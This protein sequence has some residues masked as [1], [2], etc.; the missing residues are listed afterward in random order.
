MQQTADDDH[1]FMAEALRLARRG[2]FTVRV[3]PRVGCVLVKQDKVIGSGYHVRHGYNHAEVN[4]LSDASRNAESPKGATAYV[5]LEPCAHQGN[6]PPCAES[7]AAAGIAR[8]VA[9]IK[10]PNPLVNGQGLI[11]LQQR[12]VATRCH[13]MEDEARALNRGFIKRMTDHLP[14]LTVKAAISLDGKTALTSGESKWITSESSRLDVQRLRACSCAILT[15]IDT[16]LYDDPLL[17]VRLSERELGIEASVGGRDGRFE[18]SIRFKQ[19]VKFE[20]PVRVILDTN[21]RFPVTAKTLDTPGKVIVYTCCDDSEKIAALREREVEAVQVDKVADRVD[22]KAVMYDLAERGVN[23]VWVEAGATLTGNLLAQGLVDRIIVYMAPCLMGDSS[24]GFAKLPPITSM[25][26][27][28]AL[29]I[30]DT[31]FVGSEIRVT[32][33]PLRA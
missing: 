19:P 29:K 3:N 5:T 7:L 21:L 20:Q 14:Y 1:V 13:V 15:G 9:A 17:T 27:R 2:R 28:V 25:Q 16:V 12:G 18:Q 11:Y 10:D 26:D 31:R 33:S 24:I 23:E 30:E 4:A 32:A 22:L 8:V 6:T